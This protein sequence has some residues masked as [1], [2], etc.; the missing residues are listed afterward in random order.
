MYVN[1][2]VCDHVVCVC[3]YSESLFYLCIAPDVSVRNINILHIE[4]R[5]RP[6][7][8]VAFLSYN[9]NNSD[10]PETRSGNFRHMLFLTI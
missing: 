5:M 6:V 8:P 4:N 7:G 9:D 2:D 1:I 10:G 3:N